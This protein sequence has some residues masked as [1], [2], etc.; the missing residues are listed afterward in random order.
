MKLKTIKLLIVSLIILALTL[1]F[2][3]FWEVLG[4]GER[5]APLL[6]FAMMLSFGINL[7]G[8]VLAFSERHNDRKRFIIGLFGHLILI[9]G[10]LFVTGS[11]LLSML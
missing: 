10:F 8:L 11:A 3:T 2:A 5:E 7:A 6:S 4:L 1:L 9:I